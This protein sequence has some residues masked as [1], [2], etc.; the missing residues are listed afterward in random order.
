MYSFGKRKQNCKKIKKNAAKS[1]K[2]NIFG[3]KFVLSRNG[4]KTYS[5]QTIRTTKKKVLQ[6]QQQLQSPISKL[7]VHVFRIL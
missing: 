4:L 1:C 7:L 5:E 2:L 6:T 3:L